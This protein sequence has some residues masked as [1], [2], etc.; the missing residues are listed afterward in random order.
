MPKIFCCLCSRRT[1][2]K[3]DR[4]RI[5]TASVWTL[6]LIHVEKNDLDI[7]S[8]SADDHICTKCYSVVSHY[9]MKDR[10]T[11]K[12]VKELKPFVFEPGITK[13]VLRGSSKLLNSTEKSS[14][15]EKSSETSIEISNELLTAITRN[16]I[17]TGKT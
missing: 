2:N 17:V 10:G 15:I 14:A 1:D 8:F 3:K 11:N 13:N 6:F 9:R 4:T 5:G 7:S 12:K 16:G